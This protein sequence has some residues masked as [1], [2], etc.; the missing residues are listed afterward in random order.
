M[1]SV[2]HVAVTGLPK[3]Q[4]DHAVVM[5][6]FARDCIQAITESVMP[7]LVDKLGLDTS[8]LTMRIGLHSGPVT[9]GVLRGEKSRFQVFGDT[10]NTGMNL[11]MYDV[12]YFDVARQKGHFPYSESV[13]FCCFVLFEIWNP[14][15]NE[16]LHP[17]SC[18]NG[19]YRCTWKNSRIGSNCRMFTCCRQAELA[20]QTY[21]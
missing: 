20:Q 8:D 9:A 16:T 14:A 4:S 3:P 15:Y 10:V 6:R 18:P 11:P 1:L 12:V 5:T 17:N 2:P 21:G 19:E 7:G 13:C